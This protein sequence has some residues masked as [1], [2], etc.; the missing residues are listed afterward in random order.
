MAAALMVAAPLGGRLI[1]KVKAGYVI[2]ASTLMAGIG[3]YLFSFI[4]PRTT[5]WELIYRS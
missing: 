4:D 3:I 2:F 5:A 1:G